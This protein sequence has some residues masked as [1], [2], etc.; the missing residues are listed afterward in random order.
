MNVVEQLERTFGAWSAQREQ[1]LVRTKSLLA[2]LCG[3]SGDV[4]ATAGIRNQLAATKSATATYHQAMRAQ[5][6]HVGALARVVRDIAAAEEAGDDEALAHAASRLDVIAA[7]MG[8][9]TET[10]GTNDGGKAWSSRA[11]SSDDG[12]PGA[13]RIRLGEALKSAGVVS[14]EQLD[15]ALATQEHTPHRHLG[16]ILA[17]KGYAT[18]EAVA[19]VVASQLNLAY[20]DVSRE[21]A[22]PAAVSRVPRDLA[23]RTASLPLRITQD[24]M[25]VA[26]EN[27][28]NLV[29]ISELERASGLRI[30]PVVASKDAIL[31]A[32]HR[33][34]G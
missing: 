32:Q 19:R 26:L 20:V 14:Q 4:P 17:E 7:D 15:D 16:E 30:V 9:F 10:F 5:L 22:E 27:P 1:E 33:V 18:R 24:E 3:W 6:G 25:V 21:S 28:L 11:P 8:Q 34:Y 31:S 12:K 13:E 2:R 23:I 29:S